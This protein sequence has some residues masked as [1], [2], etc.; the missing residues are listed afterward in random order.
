MQI[1]AK[2]NEEITNEL[3][4]KNIPT[5]G[6]AQEKRE[7][8]KKAYGIAFT[9]APAESQEHNAVVPALPKKSTVVNKIEE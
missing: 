8:L 7:R 9:P 4:L 5:Y 1:D 3:K 2:S 6:T